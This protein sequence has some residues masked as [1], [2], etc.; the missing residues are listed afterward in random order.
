MTTSLLPSLFDFHKTLDPFTVGYD[1]FFKDIEEVTKNVTKNVPAYPPYNIKQVSKNKY[2]IEMAVAG[3]A[4]SD[5]EITL[6]GNK[7]VIKGAAKEDQL[8]EEENFLFKGIANRNF[9]RSFTIA[10]KIEIGQAEMVN[11]MLRVWLENLVQTQDTI[12]KIAIKEKKDD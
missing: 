12:K 11:G 6:E 9:T 5:I 3:F 2:V 4:K 1:K 8:K 7:L 10:D